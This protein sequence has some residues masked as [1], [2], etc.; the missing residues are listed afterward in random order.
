MSKEADY[1]LSFGFFV[2]SH[3]PH[4]GIRLN[5]PKDRIGIIYAGGD[6]ALTDS[7]LVNG[8]NPDP[9]KNEFGDRAISAKKIR[10]EEQK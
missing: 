8:V 6:E 4:W 7:L 10:V 1:Q 5:F 3:K 2:E 9:P